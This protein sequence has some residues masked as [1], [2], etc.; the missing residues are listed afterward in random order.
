MYHNFL[1]QLCMHVRGQGS[2]THWRVAR[3]IGIR[4]PYSRTNVS[5]TI[6]LLARRRLLNV[7]REGSPVLVEYGP[8]FSPGLHFPRS[9]CYNNRQ[10]TA[11][12]PLVIKL[13]LLGEGIVG[14]VYK[15][16]ITD[17]DR[18]TDRQ[19]VA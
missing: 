3:P 12:M 5:L 10:C 13:L 11:A 1:M 6:I 9:H 14:K 4:F 18:K 19:T 2:G 16:R 15:R 8:A 17:R 7:E